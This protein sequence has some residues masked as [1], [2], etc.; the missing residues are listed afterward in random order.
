MLSFITM[1]TEAT[2]CS[3]HELA[4]SFQPFAYYCKSLLIQIA[5]DWKIGL[6][7]MWFRIT[8]ILS[9]HTLLCG[10]L[11]SWYYVI[12]CD[13]SLAVIIVVFFHSFFKCLLHN[14]LQFT[15]KCKPTNKN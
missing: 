6:Q 1:L 3:C 7:I 11:K 9:M 8:H 13:F 12:R 2:F 4:N 5:Q 15:S 14:L 10:W